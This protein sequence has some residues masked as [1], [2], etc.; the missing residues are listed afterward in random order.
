MT[1]V[2]SI[3]YFTY[4]NCEKDI[5]RKRT[6]QIYSHFTTFESKK[7]EKVSVVPRFIEKFRSIIYFFSGPNLLLMNTRIEYSL[8]YY[9]TKNQTNVTLL[10]TE[11]QT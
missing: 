4:P 3:S 9:T 2:Y 8:Y 6:K 10:Q 5:I 1:A 7:I 11:T